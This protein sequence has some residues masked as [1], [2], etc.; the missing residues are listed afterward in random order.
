MLSD[1]MV[2]IVGECV[3]FI[4]VLLI[5]APERLCSEAGREC[6]RGDTGQR[7]KILE[8]EGDVARVRETDVGRSALRHLRQGVLLFTAARRLYLGGLHVFSYMHVLSYMQTMN[9]S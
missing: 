3:Y 9:E 2:S 5:K 8:V 7:V 1:H 4:T 6:R